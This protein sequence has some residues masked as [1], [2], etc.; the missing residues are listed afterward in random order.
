MRGEKIICALGG[1]VAAGRKLGALTKRPKP[2]N[3]ATMSAWKH[4]V[5][6]SPWDWII[7]THYRELG[8]K[9]YDLMDCRE[10]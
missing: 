2:L 5:I 10:S 7:R 3:P 9:T 4:D 1:T 8:L 6:P